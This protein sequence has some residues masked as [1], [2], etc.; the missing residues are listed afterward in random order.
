MSANGKFIVLEGPDLCGKTYLINQLRD[1][2]LKLPEEHPLRKTVF[3]REP[4]GTRFA[5][6]IR[7][8]LLTVRS[9]PD[10]EL[11]AFMAARQDHV[12]GLIRPTIESGYNV[13]CDRF[14][15]STLAYQMYG[16][17]G[18]QSHIISMVIR[19]VRKSIIPDAIILLEPSEEVVLQRA[20]SRESRDVMEE[21]VAERHLN[22][23][24]AF[25]WAR[26]QTLN[27]V[28]TP[29]TI[30]TLP[31]MPETQDELFERVL[32]TLDWEL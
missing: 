16:R 22:L 9:S 2:V 25:R 32:V 20:K 31:V 1:W 23:K 12:D 17:S 29:L 6:D 13:V 21:K 28:R 18:P 11:L 27:V 19:G 26:Q 10:A 4:G 15:M 8:A 3:T 7:K 14:F 24:D 30:V 5:E